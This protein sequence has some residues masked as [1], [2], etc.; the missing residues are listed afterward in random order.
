MI[1]ILCNYFFSLPGSPIKHI[2]TSP[3]IFIPSGSS[4]RQNKKREEVKIEM[5][6]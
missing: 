1:K 4:L 6:N 2:F 5:S 3:L